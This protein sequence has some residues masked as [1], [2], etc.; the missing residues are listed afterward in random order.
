[1]DNDEE[2]N[3]YVEGVIHVFPKSDTRLVELFTDR[4]AWVVVNY[5]GRRYEGYVS[6]KTARRLD[7]YSAQERAVRFL[8]DAIA[9]EEVENGFI[10]VVQN[11]ERLINFKS[12]SKETPE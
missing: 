11:R 7:G 6:P 8:V 5:A 12:K 2:I 4:T 3:V 10:Q 1:M 9:E